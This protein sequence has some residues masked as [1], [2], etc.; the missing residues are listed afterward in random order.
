MTKDEILTAISIILLMFTAMVNWNIYSWLIL[1]AIIIALFAGWISI[2]NQITEIKVRQDVKSIEQ[3][4]INGENSKIFESHDSKLDK[5][6]ED[7]SET[8]RLLT[9]I[10]SEIETLHNHT[11]S[12]YG[13]KKIQRN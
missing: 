8:N 4:K 6:K 9:G 11:L 12:T 13:T 7:M 10:S 5:L 1:G 3:E 2:T